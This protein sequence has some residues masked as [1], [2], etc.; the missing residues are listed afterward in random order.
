MTAVLYPV[1]PNAEAALSAPLGRAA[2]ERDA[3]TRAKAEVRFVVEETG[4]GFETREA[5]LAAYAGKIEAGP[6]DRYCTLREV[7]AAVK[8]RR[9]V[10]APVR[11]AFHEG[12]RW[13]EPKAKPQTVWRLSISYW[14]VLGADA[15]A[16]PAQAR[17]AR[18]DRR[19][20]DLEP[21]QLRAMTRQRLMPVKPQQPLDI[22]LFEVRMPED[23][24]KIIPDE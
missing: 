22:G 9:P 3:K 12:R 19:A 14:K 20:E 1:A 13:P 18:R 2:R 24:S 16:E 7:V 10:V 23:P 15:E 4:P 5:A 11:P 17:A 6:E 8:G 21:Q